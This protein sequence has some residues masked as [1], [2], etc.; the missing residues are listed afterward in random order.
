MISQHD[1]QN[2]WDNVASGYDIFVTDNNI[3]LAEDALRLAN[4]QPGMQFLDVAAG[5]GA[6]S[7]PAARGGAQ[8]LAVDISPEMIQRLEA[9][10]RDEKLTNIESRVMDGM[11]LDLDDNSFDISGSQFGVMLFPNFSQGLAEMARVTRPDGQVLIIAFGPPPKIEFISIFLRTLQSAVPGFTG[12]PM[13]PPPLPFQ[14][15]D[16]ERLRQEMIKA[17]L[18]SI[19][20]ETVNWTIKI[21]S[22]NEWWDLLK[23]SNP[24]G[25]ALIADLSEE[26]KGT[27]EAALDDFLRER[28][29]R[30]TAAILNNQI[31]IAIGRK[32]PK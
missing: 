8:V 16:P 31:N 11:A 1:V 29:D 22:A 6:L 2:A 9:R 3:V 5:T 7:I 19:Q 28:S 12:L 13:D 32:H 30:G 14:M 27:A 24:I 17:E 25:A 23:A 4:L 21:A 20:I 18:G 26:E 10:A 15:A